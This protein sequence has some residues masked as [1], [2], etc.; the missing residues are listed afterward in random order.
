METTMATRAKEI[1]FII[2]GTAIYAFGLVYLN[3][4]NDLAEGGVTGITLIIRALFGIDPAYTT[5]IINIPLIL[6]GGKILGKR[7]FYYT[8]LGTVSLSVFLWIW[9]RV[10]I[11]INL[12]HDLFIVSILA[13]L[14]AGFGSGLV[15][16]NGGTT[17]GAD[18]VARILEQKFGFTM[19]KSLLFFD[20]IVLIC[21]LTYLDL[22]R[23]MYTLIVSFVFSKVVDVLASGGYAAKGVMIISNESNVI[24]ELLMSHLERG[25]TYLHGEGGFSSELKRIV[26]I[27]VSP[28]EINEVKKIVHSIDEKAFISITNVHDVDGEGFTYLKPQRRRF[29][30]KRTS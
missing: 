15:Y 12:D 8:I 11:E 16:R 27:V 21:S 10:T 6:I 5:L 7:S 18:V 24:A 17:G 13:G 25:V 20:I 23:M 14:V 19:G 22:K 26:Y 4:A 3:I 28:Q 29:K 2:F 1:S 30:L 9:Q